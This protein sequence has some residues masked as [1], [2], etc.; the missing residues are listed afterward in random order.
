MTLINFTYIS[1]Y[2]YVAYLPSTVL[3]NVLT[4]VA[5]TVVVSNIATLTVIVLS[6]IGL[7]VVACIEVHVV[8]LEVML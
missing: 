6:I 8:G 4:I 2:N 5:L 7:T 3:E 1:T